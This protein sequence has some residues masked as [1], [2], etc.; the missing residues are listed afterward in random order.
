MMQGL[1]PGWVGM[2]KG[3]GCLEVVLV[4]NLYLFGLCS[5]KRSTPGTASVKQTR[6]LP[7]GSSTRDGVPVRTRARERA[8]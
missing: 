5:G 8:V 7:L 2:G 3:T 4:P 1:H 6:V